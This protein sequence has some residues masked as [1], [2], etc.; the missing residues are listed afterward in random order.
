MQ[1]GVIDLHLQVDLFSREIKRLEK[2]HE[3]LLQQF[4]ALKEKFDVSH[5][6]LEQI[7]NHMSD[8]LIFINQKG[9]I[10]LYNPAAAT[11]TGY[12]QQEV[13]GTS[14]W[15]H[16]P[17]DLFGFSLKSSLENAE[18]PSRLFLNFSNGLEIEAAPTMIPEKGL[19]VL[20]NDR[21]QLKQLEKSVQQN[22]RLKEL[23]EMAATLAHEIRNPLGGIEGF[24]ALL[25]RELQ[26]SSQLDMADAILEGSRTL[27]KL[28]NNVLEYTCPLM[29]HF[30][31]TDLSTLFYDTVKLAKSC[32]H[33]CKV[34]IEKNHTA[35]VDRGRIQ[36]V[37]INLIRNGCE[38]H[39]PYVE[40]IL[41]K[42]G[43][44][45]IKDQGEGIHEKNLQKIFTPFF[46][47]KATGTGLGLSEAYKV[48]Q[49]HGGV[50]TVESK[51]GKG[52]CFAITHLPII[53]KK[54]TKQS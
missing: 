13:I 40:M 54:I 29:L 22:D 23:G 27:N 21:T 20:L 52:T 26:E 44:I 42:E 18:I 39:S 12:L 45:L 53:D 41:T 35:S 11:L 43:T 38:A 30:E 47:T 5:Q 6:T 4:D 15:E 36:L 10:T 33:R 19:L 25:K 37:L 2:A 32:G 17:D 7:V 34:N 49:A 16:Y 51:I 31:L 46:T 50:M 14:F 48:I 8:G 3:Q 28:V 24:A 9:V 1:E